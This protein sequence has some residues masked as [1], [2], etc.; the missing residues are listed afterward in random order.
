VEVVAPS[1]DAAP[2]PA[3]SALDSSKFATTFGYAP[4]G[5]QEAVE[6]TVN[7]LFAKQGRI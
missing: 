3:N 5:W 7:L 1:P 6:H 4:G 2:R